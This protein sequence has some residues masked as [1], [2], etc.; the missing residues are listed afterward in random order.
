M[1]LR[2]RL[3][4]TLLA[5][6]WVLFVLAF[7]WTC[8]VQEN[9]LWWLRLDWAGWLRDLPELMQLGSMSASTV[10]ILWLCLTLLLTAAWLMPTAKAVV[11]PKPDASD[12]A[13]RVAPSIAP[14]V[15]AD[16]V[17]KEKL[18]RLHQS[19]EKL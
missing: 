8:K 10:W 4:A 13:R 15:D 2:I 18:L 12:A 9:L 16:P 6:N 3:P 17:L 11:A 7:A 19:L 5:I 14:M 1:N